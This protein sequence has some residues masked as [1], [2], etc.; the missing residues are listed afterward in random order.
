M[1]CPPDTSLQSDP[2][3]LAALAKQIREAI[4]ASRKDRCNALHHDLDIGDALIAAEKRVAEGRW[5]HSLRENCFLSVRTA[6]LYARL[7]RHRAEIESEIERVGEISLRAACRLIAEPTESNKSKKPPAP[8]LLDA[9]RQASQAERT[10]FLDKVPLVEILGAMSIPL[11]RQLEARIRVERDGDTGEPNKAITAA[12]HKALSHLRSA[13]T[14]R[15]SPPVTQS[16]EIE[17]LSA[18]RG[19][20]R[21]CPEF[22][23]LAVGIRAYERRRRAA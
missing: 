9:W 1:D 3:D 5:K 17:A 7:A 4:Q 22:H 21:I 14:P 23:N 10:A 15:T 16:Q 13:D 12:L 18:L 19:I 11:R 20:A 2:Q 8:P 6:F